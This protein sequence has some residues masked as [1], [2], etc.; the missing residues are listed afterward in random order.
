MIDSQLEVYHIVGL[1]KIAWVNILWR[2]LS[3]PTSV[4]LHSSSFSEKTKFCTLE[5][6]NFLR[7]TSISQSLITTLD[8][9][10]VAPS[11]NLSQ[12]HT[13]RSSP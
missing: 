11:P 7:A 12:P 5:S 6:T 3:S 2:C 1:V 8:R 4:V 13:T 10:H 9:T